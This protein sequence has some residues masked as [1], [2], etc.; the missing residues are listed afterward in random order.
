VAVCFAGLAWQGE[1][2]EMGGLHSQTRPNAIRSTGKIFFCILDAEVNRFK[3][4]L[5]LNESF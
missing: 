3:M 4:N 2:G 5:N 1:E